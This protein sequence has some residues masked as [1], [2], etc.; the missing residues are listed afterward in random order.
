M[1]SQQ[2]NEL[3]Y[4]AN[5]SA[6]RNHL[7]TLVNSGKSLNKEDYQSAG[8]LVTKLDR[9]VFSLSSNLF[10]SEVSTDVDDGL[11]LAKKIRDA[12]AAL[13]KLAS[14]ELLE[15][16]DGVAQSVVTSGTEPK[17]TRNIVSKNKKLSSKKVIT[18]SK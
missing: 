12:K 3:Q 13:G 2:K 7:N 16:L 9:L 11:N 4:L 10:K 6:V 17:P 18:Q 1:N 14:V 15:T 8:H 5:M